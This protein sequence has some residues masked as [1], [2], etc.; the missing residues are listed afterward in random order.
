M[1]E[2]TEAATILR[3][4]TEHSLVVMDEIGRGTST[5]DGLSLAWEIARQL[6]NKNRCLTLF[7]THYFEITELALEHPE[8]VNVHLSATEYGQNLI[9]MHSVEAGP[10]NRSFGLQVAKLAGLPAQVIKHAQKRLLGLEEK[11]RQHDTQASLF[12]SNTI[13]ETATNA[14]HEAVSII[15]KT[16]IDQLSPKA[17]LQLLYELKDLCDE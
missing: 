10:A 1:V 15:A 4:A 13:S 14:P 6:V 17:A 12:D 5:F 11:Q 2:M 3:Q 9:F 16:D 8:A 7:A